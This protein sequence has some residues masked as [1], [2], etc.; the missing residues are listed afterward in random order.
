VGDKI[1]KNLS[2]E[3]A[4]CSWKILNSLDLSG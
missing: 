4:K 3:P 1:F 2:R